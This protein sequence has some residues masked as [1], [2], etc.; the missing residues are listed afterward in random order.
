AKGLEFDM[1]FLPELQDPLANDTPTLLQHRAAVTDQPD[2]VLLAPRRTVLQSAAVLAAEMAKERARGML[3]NLCVLYVAMTRAKR[4]LYLI[5]SYPGKSSEA[6][7]AAS[8][9]KQQLCGKPKPENGPE[10]T[11]GDDRV[12]CLYE[13]GERQW[14]EV[15][16]G[17]CK[18]ESEEGEVESAQRRMPSGKTEGAAGQKARPAAPA[19][20][21]RLVRV[22]PSQG[23]EADRRAD[24]LF[25]PENRATL[26]FGR[27]IH[28][29]LRE[30][31]WAETSDVEQIV[32]AFHDR[33]AAAADVQRDAAAQFR[34][35][36]AD[37][38]VRRALARPA[39]PVE[40]WREQ[41][42]EAVLGE[43]WISGAFDRVV[44]QRDAAGQPQSAA[45]LDFK[46]N[47]VA[48]P[49]EMQAKA[50]DY[51]AQLEW[52][53]RA[54]GALL[55]LPPDRIRLQILFTRPGQVV[56]LAG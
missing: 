18:V 37:P 21:R 7:T 50:E 16:S 9:L 36:L 26:D 13:N 35:A 19:A 55:R 40:L 15:E 33:S 54:L 45:I 5:T 10:W 46:S 30:V 25:H 1:V 22:E 49:A 52:Y 20:R 31:E 23:T 8:L 17:K 6:F 32:R 41:A 11:L 43:A 47:R 56:E 27:A 2:W 14:Y 34:R 53:R 3:E 24:W 4:A 51:R 28:E 44:I 29:L 42:F 39:G 12:P 48:T 38:E